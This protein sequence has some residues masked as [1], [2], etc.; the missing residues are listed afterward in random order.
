MKWSKLLKLTI[1]KIAAVIVVAFLFVPFIEYDNG[2]RCIRAPCPSSNVGS[3]AMF[4]MSPQHY[5]YNILFLNLAA[6]LIAS[7]IVVSIAFYAINKK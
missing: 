7:Y 5:M 3:V 1:G 6:G 2:T 4:I